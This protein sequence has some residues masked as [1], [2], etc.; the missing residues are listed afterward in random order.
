ILLEG[1]GLATGARTDAKQIGPSAPH[2]T[3][4]V[5]FSGIDAAWAQEMATEFALEI[6]ENEV[7]LRRRLQ[8]D[9]RTRAY[10]NDQPLSVTA[11][12][13]ISA[14]CISFQGQHEQLSLRHGTVLRD[15]IDQFAGQNDLVQEVAAAF[16][17]WDAAKNSWQEAK[18]ALANDERD[19]DF[20]THAVA[21]LQEFAPEPQEESRLD[22]QRQ[23]LK[24]A[25][26]IIEN[27]QQAEHLSLGEGGA[28]RQIAQAIRALER[29]AHLEN[30]PVT[31]AQQALD[32]ALIELDEAGIILRDELQSL[33]DDAQW[34]LART[35][36]RL[37]ALRTL[38]RKY[39]CHGDHLAQEMEALRERLD[40][41][42]SSH[43]QFAQYQEICEAAQKRYHMLADRLHK[44]RCDA[45][46]T[47]Q[48]RV[49]AELPHLKLPEA[50]FV[51]TITHD[52]ER[53]SA[54]GS[55]MVT[56]LVSMNPPQ[57]LS[58]LGTVASGGELSRLLLA[59]KVCMAGKQTADKQCLVFDEIDQGLGGGV[60]SAVGQRLMALAQHQ[61]VIVV[62][63]SPQVAACADNHWRVVK[64]S[65]ANSTNVWVEILD[66]TARVQEIARMLSGARI[67]DAALVA[68]R[69]L[70]QEAKHGQ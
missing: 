35:E 50:Q 55:D 38:A 52:K 6:A 60:A 2:A 8:A 64:S 11:L 28:S 15:I 65:D 29:L 25:A 10:C 16:A 13:Q 12:R 30:K 21:E 45:A 22:T 42:T 18:T 63:H 46:E 34:T 66:D 26:Q 32:R 19:H 69:T 61:Q 5:G 67:S 70:L 49:C 41:I 24:N 57:A 14:Q 23:R 51:I 40:N 58:P 3:A 7:I 43:A 31:L 62:T 39:Q 9:G 17:D 20:L 27:L 44:V 33:G 59:I 54:H 1:L 48:A 37:F 36:D 56:F 4:S 53:A 47:L 68:A